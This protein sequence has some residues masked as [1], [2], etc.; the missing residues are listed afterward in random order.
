M[1]RLALT[2]LRSKGVPESILADI[3]SQLSAGK[4]REAAFSYD[5]AARMTEVM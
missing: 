1:I 2:Q 4:I 5:A 3:T